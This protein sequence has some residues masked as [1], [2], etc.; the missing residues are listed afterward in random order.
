MSPV[1]DPELYPKSARLSSN[2]HIS[3]SKGFL[4]LFPNPADKHVTI[5]YKVFED[6]SLFIQVLDAQGKLVHG[7]DRL[8]SQQD[9]IIL[10]V[11]WS[12]GTYVVEL[13]IEGETLL[14]SSLL[15]R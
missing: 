1:F 6:A 14:E 9:M 4:R 3:E 8:T 12:S 15:V 2:D 13:Y 11:E 10:P 7:P 5:S